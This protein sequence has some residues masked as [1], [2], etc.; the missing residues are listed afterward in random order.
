MDFPK[1]SESQIFSTNL[2]FKAVFVEDY[3]KTLLDLLNE[4]MYTEGKV[5]CSNRL[6]A[7]LE[8]YNNCDHTTTRMSPLETSNDTLTPS[9]NNHT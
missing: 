6:N 7:A 5:C 1:Q 8:K 4:P 3:N 2:D 9:N